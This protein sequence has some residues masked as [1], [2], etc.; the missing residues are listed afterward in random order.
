MS[1]DIK[2]KTELVIVLGAGGVGKTTSSAAFALAAASEGK[3]VAVLTVDP[4]LRLAQSLGLSKLSND[5]QRVR[6]F[7]NGGCLDALWLD[8]TQSLQALVTKYVKDPQAAEKLVKQKLFQV[9]QGQLGGVEEYLGVERVLSLCESGDYDLCVLDTPPSRHAIDFLES[10]RHLLRFF[11]EGVLR[12]FLDNKDDPKPSS[13]LGRIIK[14]GKNQALDL[15]KNFLGR[16]F[17]QDVADL[18]NLARPIHKVFT[19][20]AEGI[21]RLVRE[22]T[23][24]ILIVSTLEPYPLDE[25]RLLQVELMSRDIPASTALILN[26]CL[27]NT[28]PPQNDPAFRECLGPAMSEQL[29]D[30]HKLQE[31]LRASLKSQ[32]YTPQTWC[33]VPRTSTT[34]LDQNRLLEIGCLIRKQWRSSNPNTS[35]QS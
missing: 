15:F 6:D 2:R 27:P 3:R 22:P 35:S 19:R 13:F 14:T 23:T 10:P 17:L 8:A 7:E 26:K 1:I 18:L 24:Q 34:S 31:E 4:A 11:D 29:G 20:P 21:E 9:V 30:L 25:V 33:E 16:S 32:R 5:P 12:I 28:A